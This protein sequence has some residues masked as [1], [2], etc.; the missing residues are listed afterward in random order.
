MSCLVALILF[1][2]LFMLLVLISV[3][4]YA[5]WLIVVIS[6][7]V[8]LVLNCVYLMRT[9]NSAEKDKYIG[10]IVISIV[11]LAFMIALVFI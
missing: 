11:V 10:L 8:V 9:K 7:V 6:S 1:C 3:M 2:V 4:F 5:V